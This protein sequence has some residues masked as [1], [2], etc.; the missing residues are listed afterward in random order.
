MLRFTIPEMARFLAKHGADIR[1]L[2]DQVFQLVLSV[3]T[4]SAFPTLGIFD[5]HTGDDARA[6]EG[7]RG[8]FLLLFGDQP[9]GSTPCQQ[10]TRQ[11]QQEV[12]FEQL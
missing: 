6:H 9:V 5:A 7:L 3:I 11:D 12:A 1:V 10:T 8:M 4:I 2:T